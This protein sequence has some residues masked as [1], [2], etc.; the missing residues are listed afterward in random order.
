[1]L[2]SHLEGEMVGTL[3]TVV[4]KNKEGYLLVMMANFLPKTQYEFNWEESDKY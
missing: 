3:N 2:E 4:A 1:M